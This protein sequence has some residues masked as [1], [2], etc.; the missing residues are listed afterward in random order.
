MPVKCFAIALCSGERIETSQYISKWW[1]PQ[2][3]APII[4]AAVV[5]L[6]LLAAALARTGI[7][8]I[9]FPDTPTYLEPGRNLLLH[10]RFVV[11]GLPAI[12]RTP[13]YPLF[14][15]ITSLAGLPAASIA[16]LILSVFSVFLVWK[17]SK[18]AF[19][20]DSIALCA[21]WIFAFEP[22]SVAYSV[23]LLSDTL[24]VTLLLLSVERQAVFLRE[25]RLPVLAM[26]GLWLAAATYVRPVTYYLPV[27]LALGFLL[28]LSRVPGITHKQHEPVDGPLGLY[29]KAPAVLL[30]SVLPWLAV[31]QIRNRVETGYG[32]FS[33]VTEINLYYFSAASVI[34]NVEHQG[35]QDVKNSLKLHLEQNKLNQGQQLAFMRSEAIS[36]IRAHFEVYLRGCFISLS[37]TIFNPGAGYYDKLLYPENAI[38]DVQ[39]PVGQNPILRVILFA[40]AYPWIFAEKI[41]FETV[42]LGLYLVAMRGA[43]R[44]N[45][46]NVFLWFLLGIS[47]YFIATTAAGTPETEARYRLPI[48]PIVCI[49][50]AV[51]IQRTKTYEYEDG[52]G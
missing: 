37:E 15:A 5:R 6:A 1:T 20:D 51:G 47:L 14:L 50:A 22:L 27:A 24:F 12:F 42:L 36:V 28:V 52:S 29:W 21:A 39:L 26:A 30:I 3:A 13:G 19:N 49:L 34:A 2:L 35:I 4:A 32:G 31:W 18:A 11:D 25:R 16:N 43:F 33:S 17:L 46:S 23:A 48:M 38:H 45:I 41:I 10:G 9:I 44:I 7:S 40:K 8:S